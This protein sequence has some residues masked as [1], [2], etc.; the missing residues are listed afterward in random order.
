MPPAKALR[1]TLPLAGATLVEHQARLAASVGAGPIIILV[2]RLPAALTA[3]V[4]RLRRDGL[5]VEIARGLA[6]AVDRIHPD[7]ALLLFADGCVADAGDGRADG[8][9]ARRR[10]C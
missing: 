7:E 8:G 10:R 6:D 4:D 5:R 1:A 9:G 3:A 2:E